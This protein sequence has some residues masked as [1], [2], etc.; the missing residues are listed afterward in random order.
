[1]I[2]QQPPFRSLNGC[3]ASTDLQGLPPLGRLAHHVSV[4]APVYHIRALADENITERRMSAVGRAG[5]HHEI[6]VYFSGKEY[7]ITVERQERIFNSYKS[8]EI[9]SLGDTDG[10]TIEILTPD[11]VIGI[12]YLHQSGIVGVDRHKRLALFIYKRNLIL[13]EI[14]VNG[15]LAAP[16]IDIRNTVD[17]F[18][19]EHTDK[20]ITVRHYRTVENSGYSFYRIS[21]NDRVLC[22]SPYRCSGMSF[23]FILPGYLG[24]GLADHLYF[25]H[26][27]YLISVLFIL[28]PVLRTLH[29]CG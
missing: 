7:C 29:F 14:P 13:L 6:A 17:L 5:Q 27:S 23:G 3:C 15:I 11:D 28:L 20:F 8:L 16:Q 18:P 22:V 19:T 26:S 10:C 9:C 12:F 1:M 2:E 21:A 25:T 24:Y 4:F